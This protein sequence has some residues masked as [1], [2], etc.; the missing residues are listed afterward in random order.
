MRWSNGR[1]VPGLS[2]IAIVP[3]SAPPGLETAPLA[4]T[5][6]RR[7]RRALAVGFLV[8][9]TAAVLLAI[10][11]HG[12]STQQLTASVTVEELPAETLASIAEPIPTAVGS[13]STNDA[14]VAVSITAA[15]AEA[16]IRWEVLG[17]PLAEATEAKL[18]VTGG[19]CGATL[20][21]G[22]IRYS[23]SEITIDVLAGPPADEGAHPCSAQFLEVRFREPIAGRRLVTSSGP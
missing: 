11:R 3:N 6:R 15:P 17:S 13:P 1:M 20:S 9:I 4:R 10:S 18:V 23:E 22:D 2:A 14:T 12:S 8:L 5:T 16:R 7:D 21:V 19:E